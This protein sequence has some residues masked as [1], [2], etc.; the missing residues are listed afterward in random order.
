M[1]LT[2]SDAGGML[3]F[4]IVGVLTQRI[5]FVSYTK[6]GGLIKLMYLRRRLI[7]LVSKES[8]KPYCA[9]VKLKYRLPVLVAII[10]Q[11]RD[12]NIRAI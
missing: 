3:E 8:A 1:C 9:R 7:D 6:I 4:R 5:K 2:S 12:N 10:P 11:V